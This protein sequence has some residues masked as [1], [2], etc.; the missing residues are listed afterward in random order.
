MS[1]E[2]LADRNL[3]RRYPPP[4][5]PGYREPDISADEWREA[6]FVLAAIAQ[7]KLDECYADGDDP[8]DL[9]PDLPADLRKP[10]RLREHP[11]VACPHGGCLLPANHPSA[12]DVTGRAALLDETSEDWL[13]VERAVWPNGPAS[14]TGSG[15]YSA[16]KA[17]IIR[18]LAA[19]DL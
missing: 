1:Y 6:Y 18:I 8:W 9:D 17:R 14:G 11:Y 16:L 7:K 15:V 19:S 13:R 2:E 3:D 10:Y 4:G 5:H 12:F